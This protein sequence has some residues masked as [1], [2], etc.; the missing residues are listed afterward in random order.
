MPLAEETERRLTEEVERLSR[1]ASRPH[2]AGV[3][4]LLDWLAEPNDY[5]PATN[6]IHREESPL[7]IATDT[8]TINTPGM[9]TGR[10]VAEALALHLKDFDQAPQF[11][12]LR[13]GAAG[14]AQAL[15]RTFSFFRAHHSGR[16]TDRSLM[17][18]VRANDQFRYREETGV[19]EGDIPEPLSL[20]TILAAELPFSYDEETECK[21]GGTLGML[22][23][24]E[25]QGGRA[26]LAVNRSHRR[27]GIGRCLVELANYLIGNHIYLWVGRENVV[28]QHFLLSCGLF[29]TAIN[30]S[31]AIRYGRANE[32]DD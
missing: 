19:I 22:V 24:W 2:F 10:W 16:Y 20:P 21:Q 31:G 32:G 26:M 13:P 8:I 12:V 5:L 9:Y 4:E 6:D 3:L 17:T 25:A 11:S 15:G 28:G 23:V 29:P 7:P 1:Q 27:K 30:G 14:Y 18:L